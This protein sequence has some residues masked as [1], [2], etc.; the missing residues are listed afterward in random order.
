MRKKKK[1]KKNEEKLGHKKYKY[2]VPW[3]QKSMEFF[4]ELCCLLP[5]PGPH[6]VLPVRPYAKSVGTDYK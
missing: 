4:E 5:E 1:R 6:Y 3:C 2:G